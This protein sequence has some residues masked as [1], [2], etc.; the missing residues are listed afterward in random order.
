[1]LILPEERVCSGV[2]AFNEK[3][4]HQWSL[5]DPQ[6]SCQQVSSPKRSRRERSGWARLPLAVASCF[7]PFPGRP[8]KQRPRTESDV[9]VE[10]EQR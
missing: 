8:E 3:Q 9:F 1:M 5:L 4:Q 6:I 10:G 7:P 2:H